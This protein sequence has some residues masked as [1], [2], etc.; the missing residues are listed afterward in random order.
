MPTRYFSLKIHI[1]PFNLSTNT[2]AFCSLQ[3][4]SQMVSRPSIYHPSQ[5]PKKQ[6]WLFL[7]L[8]LNIQLPSFTN[9]TSAGQGLVSHFDLSLNS[10][11]NYGRLPPTIFQKSRIRNLNPQ[12]WNSKPLELKALED[13]TGLPMLPLLH[14]Q[15]T[16][17]FPGA[18]LAG[19]CCCTCAPS[20]LL[21][22][23]HTYT[24]IPGCQVTLAS[25]LLWSPPWSL[26]IPK[27][28]PVYSQMTA[29]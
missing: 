20:T 4:V 25:L 12:V 2:S 24:P 11:P 27:I 9:L 1:Y 3:C 16:P 19:S 8:T 28:I 15:I 7:S 17:V 18:Q 13:E 6:P 10:R 14:K 21:L 5:N 23:P 26:H 22:P 29:T